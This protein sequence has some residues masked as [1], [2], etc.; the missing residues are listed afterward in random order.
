MRK[1]NNEYENPID[2]ILLDLSEFVSPFFYN[3]G[4]NPNGLTFLSLITGVLSIYFL[5]KQQ[6]IVFAILFFTSYFFDCL[7]G[8][9]ARKYK[10]ITKFGD[11]FDHYKD[12]FVTILLTIMLF[13]NYKNNKY[14]ILTVILLIILVILSNIH[15]ACQQVLYNGFDTNDDFLDFLKPLLHTLN[16]DNQE[17]CTELIKFTRFFG[18]GSLNFGVVLIIIFLHYTNKN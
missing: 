14:F 16:F 4:F 3:L 12:L 5:Y 6:I 17:K 7:D 18:T 13:Y 8:H 11:L 2:D 10:M 15:L 9:F 1:I